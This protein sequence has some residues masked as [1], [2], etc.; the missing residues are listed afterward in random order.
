MMLWREA[1][2]DFPH[3]WL[4]LVST[5][6]TACVENIANRQPQIST[7]CYDHSNTQHTQFISSRRKKRGRDALVLNINI[8]LQSCLTSAA[9]LLPVASGNQ[10]RTRGSWGGKSHCPVCQERCRRG[11]GST[12]RKERTCWGV[13]GR[14]SYHGVNTLNSTE[15]KG[16]S[17]PSLWP[18]TLVCHLPQ[19]N[20][21]VSHW[22]VYCHSD[23]NRGWSSCDVYRIFFLFKRQINEGVPGNKGAWNV[24]EMIRAPKLLLASKL[25]TEGERF[26]KKPPIWLD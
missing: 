2:I 14:R 8:L 3:K 12:T 21:Y 23:C 9:G 5:E 26:K 6:N 24:T 19:R 10:C 18:E 25:M 20:G 4:S 22:T 16:W 1:N 17:K 7:V 13:A 15:I 11:E